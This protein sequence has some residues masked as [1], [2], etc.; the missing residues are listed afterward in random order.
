MAV[1]GIKSRSLQLITKR[2]KSDIKL[3]LCETQGCFIHIKLADHGSLQQK[4]R[5]KI[6]ALPHDKTYHA[7]RE[8]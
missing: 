2:P 7:H 8:M 4:Y 3:F 5:E 6:A 1:Q